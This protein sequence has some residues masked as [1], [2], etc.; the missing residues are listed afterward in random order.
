MDHKPEFYQEPAAK[1]PL[2]GPGTLAASYAITFTGEHGAR[3]LADLVAKFGHDRPRFSGDPRDRPNFT[4]AAMID[5]ECRVLREI[6]AAIKVG[7]PIANARILSKSE[8]NE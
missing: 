7:A 5:G 3:V 6:E 8:L 2:G 1:P 4:L